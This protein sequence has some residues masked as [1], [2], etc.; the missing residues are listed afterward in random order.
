M[1]RVDKKEP[2]NEVLISYWLDARKYAYECNFSPTKARQKFGE[3]EKAG[4]AGYEVVMKKFKT[5][6]L[7][8]CRSKTEERRDIKR[9]RANMF[10]QG[11]LLDFQDTFFIAPCKA[12][13]SAE[14]SVLKESADESGKEKYQ[15]QCPSAI[16]EDYEKVKKRTRKSLLEICPQKFA[17]A[18][19]FKP[20]QVVQAYVTLREARKDIS[21]QELGKFQQEAMNE[22]YRKMYPSPKQIPEGKEPCTS[23]QSSRSSTS[24]SSKRSS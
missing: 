5:H 2:T 24:S 1:H 17:Q 4:T 9:R 21:E 14:H 8:E 10:R 18:Q 6:V 11:R 16:Q 22:C 19:D 15:Y 7:E 23:S 13:G 20:L 3:L 12:C